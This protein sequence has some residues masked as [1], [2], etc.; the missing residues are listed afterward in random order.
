MFTGSHPTLTNF[1]Q[2]A[3]SREVRT[4]Y[5]LI[6]LEQDPE[7]N[8][9]TLRARDAKRQEAAIEQMSQFTSTVDRNTVSQFDIISHLDKMNSFVYGKPV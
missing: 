2:F 3:Q 6:G 7:R 4:Y 1:L 9:R 5:D 8:A